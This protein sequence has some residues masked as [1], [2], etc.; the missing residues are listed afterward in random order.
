MD[1][2]LTELRVTVNQETADRLRAAFNDS[3]T[4]DQFSRYLGKRIDN[5][6]YLFELRVTEK[7]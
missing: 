4:R 5:L 2:K 1:A 3:V 6:C 7:A